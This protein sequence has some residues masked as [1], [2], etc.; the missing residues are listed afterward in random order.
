MVLAEQTDEWLEGR[1][2]LGLDVLRRSQ[3]LLVAASPD[4]QEVT[5]AD[6][7]DTLTA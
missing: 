6:R 5:P 7:L 3:L 1:R 2:Y 4:H